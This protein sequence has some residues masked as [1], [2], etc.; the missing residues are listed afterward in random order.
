MVS[1]EATSTN[2]I[3][4]DFTQPWLKRTI[5]HTGGKA[6]TT[7]WRQSTY[8]TLEAK[9]VLQTGGKARTTHWGQSTY[10]TLT[11]TPPM[12]FWVSK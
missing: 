12:R 8:Y 3:V 1:E 11:I 7:H 4:F 9:Q 5:Y 2:F 10:Y 6:R